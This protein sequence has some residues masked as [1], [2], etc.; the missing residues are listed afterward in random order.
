MLTNGLPWDKVILPEATRC[1]NHTAL[2]SCCLNHTLVRMI[3]LPAY[4]WMMST[5]VYATGK[6]ARLQFRTVHR[7]QNPVRNTTLCCCLWLLE[8]SRLQLPF[9]SQ[10]S[11]N[12]LLVLSWPAAIPESV[13]ALLQQTWKLLPASRPCAEELRGMDWCFGVL[14]SQHPK[15]NSPKLPGTPPTTPPF[16]APQLSS[17]VFS[18][19][20]GLTTAQL[21]RMAAG[22]AS[23]E[24]P[25]GATGPVFSLPSHTLHSRSTVSHSF[26]VLSRTAVY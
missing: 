8:L 20:G 3:V 2:D 24:P 21:Q 15:P 1:L 22:G 25:S 23:P 26:T 4:L 5:A 18:V 9:G 6:H 7:R 14:P 19:G 12:L 13:V 17:G 10:H 16:A 11:S